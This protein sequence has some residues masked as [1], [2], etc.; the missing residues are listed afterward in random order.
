MLARY[1][2]NLH[3]FSEDK[4]WD[5]ANDFWKEPP[6]NKI[7]SGCVQAY[8]I[9]KKKENG[10]NTFLGTGGS[11]IHMGVRNDFFATDKG[12][13]RKDGKVISDPVST[14]EE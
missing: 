7:V 1:R 6:N 2:G 10:G 5:T 13:I 3:V 14:R 11:G 9:A 8:Q 12:L 4:I